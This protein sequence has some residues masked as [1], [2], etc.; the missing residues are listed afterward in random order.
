MDLNLFAAINNGHVPWLDDLM[1]LA[2]AIGRAGYV[3]LVA[4]VIAAVFP[5]HRMAAWR[6]ALAIGVTY[7][8]VDGVLKPLID[9]A[10]PFEVLDA[11]RV[12]AAR[13]LTSSFPSGHA[14]SA[15]A[16]ALAAGRLFP[17][18]W[19]VW[20]LLAALIAVSRVYVGVHWPSDV[21]AGALVGLLCAWFVLGGRPVTRPQADTA[22]IVSP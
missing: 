17:A 2:S 9:R 5:Q 12:I 11:A 16:G 13:P 21:A 19:P 14:A 3:W 20:W 7:L 22:G 10:R 4:A 18:A 1:L 15:C 8:V 6:V